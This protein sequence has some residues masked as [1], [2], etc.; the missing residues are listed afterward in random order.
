MSAYSHLLSLPARAAAAPVI[1]DAAATYEAARVPVHY[2]V[3]L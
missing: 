1:C 2:N 3:M